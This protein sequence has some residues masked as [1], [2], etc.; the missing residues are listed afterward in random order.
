MLLLLASTALAKAPNLYLGLTQ[1][2]AGIASNGYG[3]EILV[4]V[5]PVTFEVL[6]EKR[7]GLRLEAEVPVDIAAIPWGGVLG[8]SYGG[9]VAAPIYIGRN[10]ER[11]PMHG[12]Y[13]GPY[14]GL[15]AYDYLAGGGV[16]GYSNV[17][18]G[19]NWRS[20]LGGRLGLEAPPHLSTFA[21]DLGLTVE[22]GVVLL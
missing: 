14:V 12:F 9:R 15:D 21:L 8:Y 13:V 10:V 18:Y 1:P 20:R 5:T 11:H 16:I 7:F 4:N 6:F 19:G 3:I 17:F 2:I 22:I